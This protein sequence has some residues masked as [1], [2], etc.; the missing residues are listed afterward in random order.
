MLNGYTI[1][2]L[3]KLNTIFFTTVINKEVCTFN[4]LGQGKANLATNE[5]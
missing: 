3:D 4:E 2:Q 5:K 1:K